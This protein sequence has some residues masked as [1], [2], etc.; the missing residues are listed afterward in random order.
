MADAGPDQNVDTGSLVTLDGSGSTD[1]DDG[2][3]P[4]TYA[5]TLE[6]PAGSM[7]TLANAD[8]ATP[9]F[10]AD[11]DG[12]YTA[13]LVVNDGQDD[14]APDA[15]NVTASAPSG[16]FE[17]GRLKYDADCAGCHAAGTYDPQGFAGDIAGTGNLLVNDL[18]TINA[19]MN[20]IMLTDQEILDLQAFLDDPSIQP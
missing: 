20:G 11:L 4:L 5:W 3:Q 10:T 6:V 19:G 9:T 1:P 13:I 15:A 18:G 2:P 14:S 17:A 12:D 16:S 8:T 7:A